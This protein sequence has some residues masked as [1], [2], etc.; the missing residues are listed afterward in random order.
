MAR[1]DAAEAD[2]HG[3][4]ATIPTTQLADGEYVAF[5]LHINDGETLLV[6]AA[7]VQNDA[8]ATPADLT[9]VIRDETAG[10]TLYQESV[11]R[12]TGDPLVELEGPAD[13]RFA[14]DNATGGPQNASAHFQLSVV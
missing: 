13:V 10:S 6:F 1:L 5:R 3:D 11:A 14:T 9:A 2:R 7:G 8:N 4:M 12:D